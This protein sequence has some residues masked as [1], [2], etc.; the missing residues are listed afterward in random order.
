[1][2]HRRRI[3]RFN[4]RPDDFCKET[5]LAR[6][7]RSLYTFGKAAAQPPLDKDKNYPLGNQCRLNRFV[8]E[9]NNFRDILAIIES[10]AATVY[11]ASEDIS[12]QLLTDSADTD[13]QKDSFY[14]YPK[15]AV[16]LL[17]ER[18]RKMHAR[19]SQT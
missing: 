5:I 14:P 1:M 12:F 11:L 19:S 6:V 8:T 17:F 10:P 2:L 4:D 9:M 15:V 3:F 13:F 18:C 16:P 7:F